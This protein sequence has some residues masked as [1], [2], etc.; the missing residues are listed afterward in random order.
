MKN[1]CTING[2]DGERLTIMYDQD[3]KKL[4]ASNGD[5]LETVEITDYDMAVNTCDAFY[6][7]D[8]AEVWGAEWCEEDEED[9]PV[10]EI[11]KVNVK[12]ETF[13]TTWNNQVYCVDICEDMAERSAWLYNVSYGV[14]SFMFGE[15]VTNQSR[16]S[17]ADLVFS[18]L[19]DY[20]ESYAEEYED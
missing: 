3:E 4:V 10:L 1:I 16:E 17:F 9:E 19:P 13:C 6:F 12:S 14:K 2:T 18:N 8:G 7:N 20:I 15:D 11:S 5:V